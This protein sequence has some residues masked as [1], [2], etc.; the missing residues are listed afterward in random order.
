MP[1]IAY[2]D[3]F[4]RDAV[5][6]YRA[7]QGRG[8]AGWEFPFRVRHFLAGGTEWRWVEIRSCQ[9]ARGAGAG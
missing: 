4:K 5:A 3:E 8:F 9:Q 2:T 7:W 6:L 1:K